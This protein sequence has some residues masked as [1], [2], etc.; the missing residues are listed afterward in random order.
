MTPARAASEVGKLISTLTRSGNQLPKPWTPP[1]LVSLIQSY[2]KLISTINTGSPTAKTRTVNDMQIGRAGAY[3]A[4]VEDAKAAQHG[5]GYE[6]A[7]GLE[8]S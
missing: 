7:Q 4:M 1:D 5:Q 8:K 2:R 6:V 3:E